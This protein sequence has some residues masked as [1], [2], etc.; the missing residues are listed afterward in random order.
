MF[1]FVWQYETDFSSSQKFSIIDGIPPL[2]TVNTRKTARFLKTLATQ[3]ALELRALP[4]IS[5]YGIYSP[6][7]NL[8]FVKPRLNNCI[9]INNDNNSSITH[10][11]NYP[12]MKSVGTVKYLLQ[13]FN[14]HNI[15][16]S[17]N[18][19]KN[20]FFIFWYE[21]GLIKIFGKLFKKKSQ[22]S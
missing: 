3:Y 21:K 6:P 19:N 11:T 16:N 2:S 7:K 13:V 10:T 15:N 4:P 22:T 5:L 18:N 12:E 17:N 20:N 8:L 9:N 14:N 1:L